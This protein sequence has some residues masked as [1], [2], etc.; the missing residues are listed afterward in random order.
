MKE[1]YPFRNILLQDYRSISDLPAIFRWL[2]D[3]HVQDSI[4]R[5]EPYTTKYCT[6][7]ALPL[8]ERGEEFG[9]YKAFMTEHHRLIDQNECR[10]PEGPPRGVP[11]DEAY[12]PDFMVRTRQPENAP[13]RNPRWLGSRDGYHPVVLTRV[14]L[15]WE[16]DLKGTDRTLESGANLRWLIIHKY[17]EGADGEGE[18][19]FLDELLPRLAQYKEV[20][21][22]LTSAT[23]YTGSRGPW[24]RVSEVWFEDSR[25]WERTMEMLEKEL[26]R[27]V[28]SRYPAFPY[29]APYEDLVGMF[30]CDYPNSD[31]LTQYRGFK[32]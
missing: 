4:S 28:W 9:L 3:V 29:L 27:P 26:P 10:P 18:S 13:L 17:P 12:T 15:F 11:Y 19:W 20:T 1:I 16:R 24:R 6:Y 31:H 23:V 2:Y 14:P 32:L 30:L 25:V 5:F 22:I 21:R 7:H 8:P